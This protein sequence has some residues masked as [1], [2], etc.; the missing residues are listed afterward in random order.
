MNSLAFVCGL[1]LGGLDW[2]VL[3]QLY[4]RVFAKTTSF[5]GFWRKFGIANLFILKTLVLFAMLYLVVVVFKLNV[6][7]FLSGLVGSLAGAIFVLYGKLK[8]SGQ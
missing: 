4:K 6:V 3:Y 7:Y 8:R 5:K 1:G 2:L